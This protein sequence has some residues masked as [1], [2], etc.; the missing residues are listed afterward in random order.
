KAGA[1]RFDMLNPIPARFRD[2]GPQAIDDQLWTWTCRR[3]T[4]EW[5]FLKA[6][7]REAGIEIRRGTTVQ[8]LI[9]G[10]P[11]RSGVPHVAGVRTADGEEIRA[12]LVI[13]ATGRGSRAPDWLSALGADVPSDQAMDSNFTYLTRFFSG[14]MPE[15]KAPPITE[16]GSISILTLPADRGTWS[17]TIFV[18]SRDSELRALRDT[19]VWTKVLRACP[20]HAHWLDGEP[21]SELLTMS[22]VVDRC[23]RF[24]NGDGPFVTGFAAIA[25]AWVC[26]NPSAGRGMTVGML[27]ARQLRDSVRRFAD[28][29]CQL[30]RDFDERTECDI[31]P[32]YDAQI[33]VDRM[34]FSAMEASRAGRA[35]PVPADQLTRDLMLLH[36]AMLADGELFRLGLEYI[37]TL[38]T[39]QEIMDRPGVRE[40]MKIALDEMS[41]DGRPAMPGPSRE[42]LLAL[43]A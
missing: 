12:E 5:V 24:S 35:P 19:N 6:A 1:S 10:A 9:A 17:V 20:L 34:R 13:D 32:W 4:G 39:A 16:M 22:G 21:I 31:K 41:R 25:D 2:T 8:S 27:H 26:T 15:R 23:R 38:S 11:G 14:V 29:P 42:Q 28:D 18:S 30:V 33:A 3:P 43:V 37:A 36:A 7:E 40:R